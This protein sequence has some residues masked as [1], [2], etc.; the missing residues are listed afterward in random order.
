MSAARAV[1]YAPAWQDDVGQGEKAFTVLDPFDHHHFRVLAHELWHLLANRTD[2][3][4]DDQ[5]FCP[6]LNGSDNDLAVN[7]RRRFDATIREHVQRVRP[8]G[9]LNFVGNSLRKPL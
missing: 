4:T 7:T 8:A 2:M 1:A 9:E 5:F 3:A 6:S